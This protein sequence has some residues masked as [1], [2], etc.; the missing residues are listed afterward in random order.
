MVATACRRSAYS[1]EIFELYLAPEYQGVGLGRRM[2]EAARSDLAA[3]GYSTF[4]VWALG[5][6]DRAL[7]FYSVW[8]ARSCAARARRFGDGDARARRVRLR[9]SSV[10]QSEDL[11]AT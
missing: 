3:H 6:N 9:R 5:G 7:E 2:F 4:V 1:G 11:L 10:A 8:A